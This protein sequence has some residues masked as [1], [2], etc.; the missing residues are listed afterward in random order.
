M[1]FDDPTFI[2]ALL[3]IVAISYRLLRGLTGLFFL[4]S[5]EKLALSAF[6]S[7][8]LP[9]FNK[10]DPKL[11][12][13]FMFRANSLRR[14]FKVVGRQGFQV[15]YEVRL[16]VVAALVQITFGFNHYRLPRFRTIFVYPD[17]YRNPYTGRVHD[18]EVHPRGLI[19]LS[20]KKLV[21]GFEDPADK[22]N[23]GL[24]E[25]AHALMHT[26]L[27]TQEHEQG[28]DEYLER[29]I[30]LSKDEIAK[31]NSGGYHFLRPYAGASVDEFFAVAIEHFFEAP[32]EFAS[33]LPKLY[34]KLIHL[35]KQDP[36]RNIFVIKSRQYYYRRIA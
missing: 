30:N 19:I 3:F 29:V 24:H 15:T 23:L 9:Y 6:Y 22:I 25:M 36:A 34:N 2:L 31:I 16:M 14:S 28:L 18:G 12:Y 8:N 27:H 5:K 35:L 13:R 4:S 10:L 33:Q 21:K 7:K 17:S 1:P 32:V 20:W 11:Q 26:I